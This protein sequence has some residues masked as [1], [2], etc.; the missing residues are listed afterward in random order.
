[1]ILGGKNK[2]R[3]I[4]TEAIH[5]LRHLNILNIIEKNREI[6]L[7][8]VI[9]KHNYKRQYDKS[10]VLECTNDDNGS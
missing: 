2:K 8:I 9:S 4:S 7:L 5:K 6:K 3:N 10:K 1:M